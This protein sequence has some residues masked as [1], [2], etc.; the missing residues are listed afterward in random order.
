MLCAR[1]CPFPG[2]TELWSYLRVAWISLLLS[3]GNVGLAWEM[4]GMSKKVDFGP[5]KRSPQHQL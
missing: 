3:W 1:G 5:R 2:D 4:T